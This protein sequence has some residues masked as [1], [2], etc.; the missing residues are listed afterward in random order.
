MSRL[1]AVLAF[2][3]ERVTPAIRWLPRPTTAGEA[4]CWSLP[5][6][7]GRLVEL[8][9]HGA[10]A[11]LSLTFPLVLDAQQ[12]RETVAWVACHGSSF[13]PPDAAAGG[14][15]LEQLPVVFA[16]TA[17]AAVRAGEK[18]LRCGAFGLVVIDLVRLAPDAAGRAIAT[19]PQPL[20]ARLAGLADRHDAT[21]VV[22][23]DRAADR[24]SLGSPV[25]LRA[26]AS[27]LTPL[28]PQRP[29]RYTCRLEA[30]K[31]RRHPPGWSHEEFRSGPPGL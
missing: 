13:F 12:R 21:V 2:T 19:V 31:D 28:P 11:A 18:L 24:P 8:S 3:G 27:R 1:A 23:T 17:P 26:M 20:L 29:G 16:P 22:L 25:S 7:A 4:A 10:S 14:I 6:L 30:I 9:G 5:A 15:D